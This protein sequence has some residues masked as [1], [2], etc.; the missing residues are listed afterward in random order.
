MKDIN[1]NR[2]RSIPG[3][4]EAIGLI[5]TVEQSRVSHEQFFYITKPFAR[6]LFR[7]DVNSATWTL[8]HIS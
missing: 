8:V 2:S 3:K 4:E 7:V 1:T 6:F 5:I